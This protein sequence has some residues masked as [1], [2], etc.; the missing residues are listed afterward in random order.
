M[1][2]PGSAKYA[3]PGMSSPS[4]V[5]PGV[6]GIIRPVLLLPEGIG[7]RLNPA[8]PAVLILRTRDL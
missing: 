5:E 8:Q 4:L 7:G 2:M 3:V 6:F 1:N